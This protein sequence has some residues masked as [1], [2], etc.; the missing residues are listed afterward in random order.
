[1][2][3]ETEIEC[4]RVKLKYFK[5]ANNIFL[6]ENIKIIILSICKENAVIFLFQS[7]TSFKF[8]IFQRF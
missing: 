8:L 7:Y 3:I 6:I 5:I 4:G 2:K 1:M